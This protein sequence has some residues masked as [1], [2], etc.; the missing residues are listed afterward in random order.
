MRSS[1]KGFTLI[2]LLVVIAIIALLMSILMPALS[3]VKAQAKAVICQ[4]HLH[5]WSLLWKT[6]IDEEVGNKLAGQF[7]VRN[8]LNSSIRKQYPSELSGEMRICPMATKTF[9]EGGRN[10]YMAWGS[11]SSKGSFAVNLWCGNNKGDGKLSTGKQEF[12]GT[13]YVLG[14]DRIPLFGD[15]Q[16]SNADPISTDDPLPYESDVWTPSA[17]EMQRFCIKRHP[18]YYIHMLYLDLSARRITIKELWR[19]KWHRTYDVFSDLPIW[20]DWMSDVPEPAF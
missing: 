18:P 1:D 2:E 13:A 5:Q 3:K 6:F 12:W 15:A 11:K 16:H 10:P 20:P 8:S 9:S 19:Q 14:A 4:A 17:H 7:P